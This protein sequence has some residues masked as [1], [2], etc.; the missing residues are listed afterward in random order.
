[1]RNKKV[2]VIVMALVACLAIGFATEAAA[3]K[4]KIKVA[5]AVSLTVSTTRTTGPY[6]PS[7]ASGSF[8]GAVTARKKCQK[9]RRVTILKNGVAIGS[10]FTSGTGG[11]GTTLP[12]AGS[13]TYQAQVAK[14]KRK[15]KKA[16]IICKAT[17]SGPVTIP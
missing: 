2:L 14:K 9:G 10:T 8:S 17:I 4:K 16:I 1:M 11:Y 13:G 7:T 5:S 15:T 3:K 12:G 6:A